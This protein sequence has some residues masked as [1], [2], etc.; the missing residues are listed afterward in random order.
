MTTYMYSLL[1]IV[2]QPHSRPS[3]DSLNKW[4]TTSVDIMALS[5]AVQTVFSKY[6]SFQIK[7]SSRHT[8]RGLCASA[9]KTAGGT[10]AKEMLRW[11]SYF[12]CFFS[13]TSFSKQMPRDKGYRAP[14]KSFT[15]LAARLLPCRRA[16]PGKGHKS[17]YGHCF[18][19]PPF[20]ASLS[21]MRPFYLFQG[22]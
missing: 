1:F 6:I 18:L 16:Q 3:V 11:L 8:A 14:K 20:Q 5:L 12:T 21:S 2:S 15:D 13:P 7:D 17:A 9:P 19:M 22:A 10:Q 4:V